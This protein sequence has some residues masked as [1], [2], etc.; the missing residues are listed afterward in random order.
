MAPLL[1]SP[2]HVFPMFSPLLGSCV[3]LS[4]SLCLSSPSAL[5]SLIALLSAIPQKLV[6]KLGADTAKQN[7]DEKLLLLYMLKHTLN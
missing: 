5:L 6:T 4:C 7:S 2:S 3:V 1:D